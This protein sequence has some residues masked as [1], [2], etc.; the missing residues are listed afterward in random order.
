MAKNTSNIHKCPQCGSKNIDV[1]VFGDELTI[2]FCDDCEETTEIRAK[3][4]K[5]KGG[6]RSENVDDYEDVA[7]SWNEEESDLDTEYDRD[8]WQEN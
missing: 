4:S 6:R 7:A 8:E 5:R 3:G 2:I 1:E